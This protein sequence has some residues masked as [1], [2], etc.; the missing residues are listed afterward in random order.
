MKIYE[1]RIH[2]DF[3]YFYHQIHRVLL[4]KNVDLIGWFGNAPTQRTHIIIY[5][6][7]LFVYCYICYCILHIVNTNI[8]NTKKSY[9][10]GSW[11][12]PFSKIFKKNLFHTH[13][14][15]LR[16]GFVILSVLCG[17]CFLSFIISYQTP[18]TLTPIFY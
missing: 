11:Q 1:S 18:L 14:C 13:H 17:K 10:E 2:A 3:Y 16:E 15:I 6:S 8:G 9:F 12:T 4:K 7:L 5:D